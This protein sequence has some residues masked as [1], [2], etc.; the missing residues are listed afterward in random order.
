[1]FVFI[2]PFNSQLNFIS[3]FYTTR[4]PFP[5]S[6]G[7]WPKNNHLDS[8]IITTHFIV[9]CVDMLPSGSHHL[10]W[11]EKNE[12]VLGNN[13]TAVEFG[14]VRLGVELKCSEGPRQRWEYI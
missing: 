14:Q 12:L 1:M 6:R 8:G 9:I 13:W 7:D 3:S 5:T 4:C 10:K 11:G 2:N